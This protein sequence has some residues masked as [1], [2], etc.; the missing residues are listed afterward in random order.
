MLTMLAD[1]FIQ[2]VAARRDNYVFAI[3]TGLCDDI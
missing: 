2:R 3:V 1:M